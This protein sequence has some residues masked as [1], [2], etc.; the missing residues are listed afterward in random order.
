MILL[1]T[2]QNRKI[3]STKKVKSAGDSIKT[4]RAFHFFRE[5]EFFAMPVENTFQAVMMTALVP[6]NSE[7]S[8]E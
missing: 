7:K 1:I 8:L 6:D 3:E 4:S 5:L 2:T